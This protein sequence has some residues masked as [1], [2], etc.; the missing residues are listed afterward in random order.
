MIDIINYETLL[1]VG[2]QQ[3]EPQRFLFV[4][5]QA[6][7]PKEHGDVE[8]QRF[9]SGRGGELQPIMCVDKDLDELSN[10]SN[11]VAES[12]QMKQEWTMVLVA[13][14]A[15][16]N[17]TPPSSEQAESALKMMEQT[18]QSGADL[19]KYLAFDRKGELVQFS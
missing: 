2:R 4:F 13:C 11:L 19:S 9:H 7:L 14:L 10:F 15:G 5:L 18:V 12:E 17:G 16:V 8:A 6:S 3:L 1:E